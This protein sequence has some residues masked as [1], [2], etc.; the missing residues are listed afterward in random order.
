MNHVRIDERQYKG[1]DGARYRSVHRFGI[2]GVALAV[3][4][5][6]GCAGDAVTDGEE[7]EPG[8]GAADPPTAGTSTAPG[9]ERA[10][11]NPFDPDAIM[12]PN[13]IEVEPEVLTPGEMAEV[14]FPT[15][16]SRGVHYVLD[17]G[18]GGGW[19]HTYHLTSGE[20]VQGGQ[21]GWSPGDEPFDVVD[22]EVHGAGPDPVP[23]PDTAEPGEYRLCTGNRTLN[24]CAQVTIGEPSADG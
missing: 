10:D 20:N 4:L 5:L 7:S 17:R 15:E 23:V 3:V 19:E 9:E 18:V 13:L 16:E 14:H 8:G 12:A 11:G 1:G 6:S 24:L 2:W 21:P 22:V